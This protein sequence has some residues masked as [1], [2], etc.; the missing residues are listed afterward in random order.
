MQFREFFG[1][2]MARPRSNPRWTL[3]SYRIP[4]NCRNMQGPARARNISVAYLQQARLLHSADAGAHHIFRPKPGMQQ[5]LRRPG[6][7]CDSLKVFEEKPE[8]GIFFHQ[9]NGHQQSQARPVK[10][11]SFAKCAQRQMVLDGRLPS[12]QS[13]GPPV[14]GLCGRHACETS[15]SQ[16]IVVSSEK[17]KLRKCRPE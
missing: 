12:P 3:A 6:L 11:H 7:A 13:L 8:T 15:L 10:L 9:P 1:W 14:T 5:S 4:Q 17:W 2:S 16:F